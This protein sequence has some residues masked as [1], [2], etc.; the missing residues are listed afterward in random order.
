MMTN[1]EIFERFK[2]KFKKAKISDYR[3]MDPKFFGTDKLRGIIIWLENG[4]VI[5]YYPKKAQVQYDN[6]EKD[7]K[8]GF[9]KPLINNLGIPLKPCLGCSHLLGNGK[10]M[11]PMCF[12]TMCPY[13]EEYDR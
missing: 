10:L 12:T 7:R 3:P 11:E 4:D 9:R 5:H 1:A 8:K 2:K 6:E 13:S